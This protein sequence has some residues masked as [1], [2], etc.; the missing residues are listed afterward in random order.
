MGIKGQ[1]A[2]MCAGVSACMQRSG[3]G[4]EEQAG[5]LIVGTSFCGPD[6]RNTIEII[7]IFADKAIP[8]FS[9]EETKYTAQMVTIQSG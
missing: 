8:N 1:H 2:C 9:G 7:C 6:E 3:C 4:N 5:E